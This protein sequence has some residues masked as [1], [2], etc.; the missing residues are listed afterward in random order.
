MAKKTFALLAFSRHVL[1][2]KNSGTNVVSDSVMFSMKCYVSDDDV[3]NYDNAKFWGSLT[4]KDKE[5][6]NIFQG[7]SAN[8]WYIWIDSLK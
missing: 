5:S 7:F 4:K 6:S 1:T 8:E 2:N 3:G